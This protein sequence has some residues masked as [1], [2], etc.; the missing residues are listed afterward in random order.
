MERTRDERFA[1]VTSR[2]VW[3]RVGGVLDTVQLSRR[4]LKGYVGTVEERLRGPAREVINFGLV[5]SPERASA[6]GHEAR[7]QDV[8]ILVI[9]VTTYALS[10]RSCRSFAE[11]RF[12]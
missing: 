1:E 12:P 11:R 4:R 7:V 5:D 2:P 3:D 9:Y 6:V 8:D 10:S